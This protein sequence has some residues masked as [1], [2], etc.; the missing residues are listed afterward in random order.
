MAVQTENGQS[1]VRE[2]TAAISRCD[3]RPWKDLGEED[4]ENYSRWLRGRSGLRSPFLSLGFFDAVHT[5][6]SDLSVLV[7]GNGSAQSRAILPVHLKNR[8]ATPAG[9]AFNDAQAI[10]YASGDSIDA[11]RMMRL[12]KVKGYEFHALLSDHPIA[13]HEH[14]TVQRRVESFAAHWGNHSSKYLD[15]LEREHRTIKK[16]EQK[17][18]QMT[19]ELGPLSLEIDCRDPGLLSQAIDAKRAQYRRT[20]IL[21]HF[22]PTWTRSLVRYLH[23]YTAENRDDLGR[24]ETR[25]L[26]S[27]LRAGQTVV[28]MHFGIVESGLLH[29]WFPVYNHEFSKYS[30]GTALYKAIVGAASEHGIDTLDMGYGE[31]PYKRKQTDRVTHVYQGFTSCCI[32]HR[33]R[34]KIAMAATVARE[35]FLADSPLREILKRGLRRI[36]PNEGI[37]K[38]R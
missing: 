17:S 24:C 23:E 31:Q 37:G 10:M 21:D 16:Q 9:R 3:V 28:A 6:R 38:L 36:F 2:A 25:G 27:V 13:P 34:R 12:G 14:L 1:S 5:V 20:H 19:R 26:L 32:F 11:R 33:T 15:Q 22:K 18:R 35:R 8:I 7:A 29:Y 4:R 30:P